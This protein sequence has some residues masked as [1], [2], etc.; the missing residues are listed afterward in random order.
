M[1]IIKKG[2]LSRVS[3]PRIYIYLDMR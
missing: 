3:S 1:N 2:R